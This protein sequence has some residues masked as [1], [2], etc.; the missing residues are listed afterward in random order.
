MEIS[1]QLR[2]LFS[3]NIEEQDES[4]IVEV[5]EQEVHLGDLQ[6]GDT[7]RVAVLP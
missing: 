6:E 2:C 5:P 4:Y 1:E 3:A 7:Y